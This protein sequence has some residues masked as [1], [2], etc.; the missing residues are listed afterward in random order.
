MKD[1]ALCRADQCT[2][3]GRARG[4]A[5]VDVVAKLEKQMLW[6][7]MYIVRGCLGLFE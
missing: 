5:G 4:G 1:V 2:G 3:L 7:Q 6:P